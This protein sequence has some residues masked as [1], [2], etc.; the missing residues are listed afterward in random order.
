MAPDI[1]NVMLDSSHKANGIE[2]TD[3]LDANGEN[4]SEKDMEKQAWL[5]LKDIGITE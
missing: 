5:R 3:N 2:N 4:P 1:Q